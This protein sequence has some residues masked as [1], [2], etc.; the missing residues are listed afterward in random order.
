MK[1]YKSLKKYINKS[2]KGSYYKLEI[3]VIVIKIL[4]LK[5]NKSDITIKNINNCTLNYSYIELE[6]STLFHEIIE[7]IIQ[8]IKDMEVDELIFV[9]QIYESLLSK[10][11]KKQ[12]GQVYTPVEIIKEMIEFNLK[13]VEID[14]EFKI[15]DP[16]CGGGYFLIEL[17]EYINHNY[18]FNIKEVIETMIYG[19]DINPVA[20][21]LTKV[22]ILLN[23][24]IDMELNNIREMD[25][26][27]DDINEKFD[28]VIGN[29][30]YIGHKKLNNEYRIKI[31]NVYSEVF[32]EKADIFY[33]FF[34]KSNNILKKEGKIS[35]IVSR[36][37]LNAKYGDKLRKYI[38]QNNTI[39]RIIDFEDEG[40][41]RKAN[42]KPIIIDLS[43]VKNSNDID[44]LRRNLNSEDKILKINKLELNESAWIFIDKAERAVLKKIIDK[45]KYKLCEC[46]NLN[47]GVITGCD[48]AFI[49]EDSFNLDEEN[50]LLKNWVKNSQIQAFKIK[51]SSKKIIYADLI[52]NT[53]MVPKAL[54]HIGLHKDR[55]G[56]RRE[57]LKGIREWYKLQW[58]RNIELFENEK[59]MFPYKAEKNRFAL[60]KENNICSAD[61][62]IITK[63]KEIECYELEYLTAYLNSSVAEYF[64]KMNAKKVGRKLYEYYPYIIKEIPIAQDKNQNIDLLL[65]NKDNLL[66]NTINDYFYDIF[67][68]DE[69]EIKIIENKI[70]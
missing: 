24:N 15:I 14:K 36:Y 22:T 11:E 64:I 5:K 33:C 52:E 46:Y 61:I 48:K 32:Y 2:S 60:D 35:F 16:S 67:N 62:Y 4:Y 18:D 3:I 28:I 57:C 44:Y 55:L 34:V 6:K 40:I 25:F 37:F 58:G 8:I 20:I 69:M 53:E 21:F 9:G 39:T 38:L 41:F 29:P 65:Q 7:D 17:I 43:N 63:K 51:K 31:S 19:V 56:R 50:Y 1:N 54:R 30:P 12:L 45:G 59:I 23:Y 27:L 13:D 70:L 42:I 66:Q 26:L 47:Q 68:L 10:E 49:V